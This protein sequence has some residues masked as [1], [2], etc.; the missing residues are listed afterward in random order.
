VRQVEYRLGLE[1][2][3][4]GSANPNTANSS[5]AV[6]F[7]A[8]EMCVSL[9]LGGRAKRRERSEKEAEAETRIVINYCRH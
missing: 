6:H 2:D 9:E 7:S 3:R 8:G 4:R 1:V 5:E